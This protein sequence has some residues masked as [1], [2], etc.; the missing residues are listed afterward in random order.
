MGGM[1]GPQNTVSIYDTYSKAG[2]DGKLRLAVF[3]T[4]N[5]A[6][7]I[8]NLNLVNGSFELGGT[9]SSSTDVLWFEAEGS[10]YMWGGTFPKVVS[11]SSTPTSSGGIS[12]TGWINMWEGVLQRFNFN[13]Q[14]LSTGYV[15]LPS[16]S[17]SSRPTNPIN[18]MI[19]YNTDL[20]SMEGYINGQWGG[21]GGA[22]AN[23]A[24]YENSNTLTMSYTLTSGKNG[25]SAGPMT[26]IDGITISI[27]D[28]STWVIV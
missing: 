12:A 1:I 22:Q 28:G 17:T 20:N 9:V 26:M 18:G 24:I 25:F 5:H 2:T 15:A 7:K 6:A 8:G 23:G 21:V 13:T 4:L 3:N 10:F 11:A 14:Y 27:P 19:R 16:G